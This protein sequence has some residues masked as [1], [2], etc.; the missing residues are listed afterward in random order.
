[1]S[2]KSIEMQVAIPRTQ[3]AG[4]IQDQLQQ[5]GQLVQDALTSSQL[6]T[7]EQ[8]RKKVNEYDQKDNVQNKQ[9][10][11]EKVDPNTIRKSNQAL[12]HLDPNHPY[13][14]KKIDLNG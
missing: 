11:K 5:R 4:K 10:Q 12:T 6:A 9:K 2:W 3:E 7:E 14:G 1:M 8:K 13:L